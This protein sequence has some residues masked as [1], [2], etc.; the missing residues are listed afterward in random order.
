M[1]TR[2]T[3]TII[4]ELINATCDD[5]RSRHLL[6][7]SLHEL[8]RVAKVEQLQRMRLDVE[9]ALGAA[10]DRGG[11]VSATAGCGSGSTGPT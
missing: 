1:L 3:D 5:P 4:E 8:V 2:V 6:A 11:D 9:L 10:A 7:H